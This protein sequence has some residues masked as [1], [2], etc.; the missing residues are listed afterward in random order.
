MTCATKKILPAAS[1]AVG[2]A[3]LRSAL[4]GQPMREPGSRPSHDL[5]RKVLCHLPA[6][7]LVETADGAAWIRPALQLQEAAR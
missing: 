4:T 5:G 2:L 6:W 1:G 3:I 7:W